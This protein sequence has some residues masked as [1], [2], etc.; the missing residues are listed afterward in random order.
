MITV[1]QVLKAFHEQD[2]EDIVMKG[3]VD[4]AYQFTASITNTNFNS[5]GEKKDD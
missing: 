5:K 1:S 4:V 2:A 3:L